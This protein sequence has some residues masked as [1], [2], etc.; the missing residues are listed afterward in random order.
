MD[1]LIQVEIRPVKSCLSSFGKWVLFPLEH[2][3]KHPLCG[4][5]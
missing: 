2:M 3:Q 5:G 1:A 4:E